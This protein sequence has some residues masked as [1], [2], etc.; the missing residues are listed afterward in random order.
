V[1]QKN[2]STSIIGQS[3]LSFI[4]GIELLEKGHSVL[5]LD[6]DRLSFGNLYNYG[7]TAMDL[8]FFSSWAKD[9][10]LQQYQESRFFRQRPYVLHWSGT[11]ILLGA[12]PWENLRELY[13]KIPDIFNF[14]ETFS[15]PIEAK[16]EINADFSRLCHRLGVNGFRFKGLEDFNFDYVMSQCPG[17]IKALFL[18][19]KKGLKSDD[20][21]ASFLYFARALFHKRLARKHSELEIFHFFLCLLSPHFLLVGDE[22]EEVLGLEFTRRGGHLKKT[23]VREWKFYKS[24]PWSMELASFEGIIHPKKI[25]FLG[26]RTEGLPLKVRHSGRKFS[27][28]SFS[29][30]CSDQ[31]LIEHIGSWHFWAAVKKMGTDFPLW[32]LQIG[33]GVIEGLYLYREKKGSKLSFYQSHMQELLFDELEQ[34]LPGVRERLGSAKFEPSNEV[35]LDQSLMQSASPMARLDK[36]SLFDYSRPVSLTK[37]KNVDYYGPLK[38]SPLGLFGQLLELNETPNYR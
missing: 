16:E 14:Q 30:S 1:L 5:L 22:L 35:Y 2:Y 28:I 13:R 36:V 15:E 17:S 31:R 21:S 23:R 26:A 11:R 37:L 32:R 10:G 7:L 12:S 20:R 34:W 33:D 18:N 29:V 24:L 4:Y 9:R 19:F 6:D 3:Y 8:S 38:G 27:G 25:A